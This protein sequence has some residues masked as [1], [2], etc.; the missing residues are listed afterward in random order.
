M[1]ISCPHLRTISSCAE[2]SRGFSDIVMMEILK[3]NEQTNL[4]CSFGRAH[5]SHLNQSINI[6]S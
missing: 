3:Q 2:D 4:C 1:T 5:N 6:K